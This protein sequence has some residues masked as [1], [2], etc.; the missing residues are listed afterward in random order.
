ML[1][2]NI[3]IIKNLFKYIY[4]SVVTAENYTCIGLFLLLLALKPELGADKKTCLLLDMV[5][6]WC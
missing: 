6:H 3:I 4:Y 5:P 2:L 1:L